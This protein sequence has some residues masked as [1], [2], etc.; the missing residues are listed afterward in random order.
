M[1]LSL[2][3]PEVWWG[4]ALIS[5]TRGVHPQHSIGPRGLRGPLPTQTIPEF[6]VAALF[7]SSA[8]WSWSSAS[9]MEKSEQL[10][11]PLCLD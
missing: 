1:S 11:T 2:D 7:T 6:C 4:E 3:G 8:Q 9:P 5:L 10:Y